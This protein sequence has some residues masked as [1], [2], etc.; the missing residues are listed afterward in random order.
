M[1]ASET[2]LELLHI[3][4]Y[5]IVLLK[6]PENGRKWLYID[7]SSCPGLDNFGTLSYCEETDP[8]LSYCEETDPGPDIDSDWK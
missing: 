2:I 4:W 1:V 5:H 8:G 7:V 3:V 6:L